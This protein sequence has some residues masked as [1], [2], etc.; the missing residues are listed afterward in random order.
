MAFETQAEPPAPRL[1]GLQ[2]F[3]E[4]LGQVSKIRVAAFRGEAKMLGGGGF[5][6]FVCEDTAQVQLRVA[7][8]RAKADGFRIFAEGG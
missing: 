6:A 7:Q 5:V 2:F 1:F 4:A 8:I 3:Q